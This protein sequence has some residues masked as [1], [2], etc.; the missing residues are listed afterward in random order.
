M[1]IGLFDR[2]AHDVGNLQL[3]GERELAEVHDHWLGKPHV[4]FR[5]ENWGAHWDGCP[6]MVPFG[7]YNYS[8]YTIIF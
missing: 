3:L 4:N 5:I 8:A 1:T 6:T 7:Q 2:L